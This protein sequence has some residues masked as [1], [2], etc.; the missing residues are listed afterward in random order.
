MVTR[1]LVA[2]EAKVVKNA[3]CFAKD[4]REWR[5][6][7]AVLFDLRGKVAKVRKNATFLRELRELRVRRGWGG[8][9]GIRGKSVCGPFAWGGSGYG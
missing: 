5:G 3:L 6:E 9:R 1:V 7:S 8:F 4:A 2:L